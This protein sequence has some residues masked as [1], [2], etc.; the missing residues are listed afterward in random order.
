MPERTPSWELRLRAIALAGGAM[1]TAGCGGNVAVAPIDA[2]S[3]APGAPGPDAQSVHNEASNPSPFC[4]NASPDP[5]C[6]YVNCGQPMSPAC[7]CQSDGGSFE[8]TQG[9]GVCSFADAASADAA[10][11]G[12]GHD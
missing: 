7:A 2:S 6:P 3:D 1:T 8:Y 10:A 5:C 9:G 4:C 11:D 12:D